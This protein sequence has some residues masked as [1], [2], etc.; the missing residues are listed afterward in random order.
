MLENK[1]CRVCGGVK[2]DHPMLP[3]VYDKKK[4]KPKKKNDLG[5]ER[6]L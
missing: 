1:T 4:D 3:E 5:E 6:A 2:R